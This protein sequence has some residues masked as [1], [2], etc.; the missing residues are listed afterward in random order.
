MGLHCAIFIIFPLQ[1]FGFGWLHFKLLM[2]KCDPAVWLPVTI[3]LH[4]FSQIV[5]FNGSWLLRVLAKA[6]K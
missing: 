4:M 3:A 1:S 5:F 6:P 2:G